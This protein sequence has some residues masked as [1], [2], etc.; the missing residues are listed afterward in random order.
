MVSKR[1]LGR[2]AVAAAVA[3]T[4]AG[5]TL[6]VKAEQPAKSQYFSFAGK[7]PTIKENDI[8]D[9]Q[10]LVSGN[11]SN[12]RQSVLASYWTPKFTVPEKYPAT[13]TLP[14]PSSA[15]ALARS[16]PVLPN[17]RTHRYVP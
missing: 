1:T 13:A 5:G 4:L 3:T 8:N 11:Q 17:V 6:M 10:V 15:T 9:I 14:L 7:V 16:S 12:G 2:L